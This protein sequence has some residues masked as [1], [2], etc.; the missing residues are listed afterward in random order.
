MREYGLDSSGSQ[1]GTVERYREL[2]NGT[3]N[4]IKCWE[5]LEKLSHWGLLEG[6]LW[7]QGVS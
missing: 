7:L 6:G 3:S 4:S 5:L 1:L 2:G